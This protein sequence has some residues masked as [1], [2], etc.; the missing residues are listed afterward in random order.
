M[1][2]LN[3]NKTEILIIGTPHNTKRAITP[4]ITIC[5]QNVTPSN[6]IRNLGL[7]MDS[8]LSLDH[9]ISNIRKACYLQLRKISII[10]KYL[11]TETTVRLVCSLVL[12]RLDY[13][14]ALFAGLQEYKLKQLQQIQ[15]HAARVVNKISKKLHITP[16]LKEL[17]W[18][19]VDARIKY[20]LASLAYQC[21]Y[22]PETPLYLKDMIKQYEP[23]RS[24]RSSNKNIITQPRYKL[25]TFG[26]RTFSYQSAIIWNSLPDDLKNTQ[27][28]SSFKAKLKTYLFLQS[29][30]EHI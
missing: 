16:T 17:H 3:E 2:K 9:H 14:N 28:L 15:N 30:I 19:P 5:N 10:R 29:F 13:C 1:L 27:T 11:T 20:K 4:T 23:S 21:L 8:T 26:Q 12:P 18:L 6:T 22:I 7:T 25:L 24:L